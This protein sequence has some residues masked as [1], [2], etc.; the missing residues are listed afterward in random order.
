MGY[1]NFS[2]SFRKKGWKRSFPCLVY[3]RGLENVHRTIVV[4]LSLQPGR[5]KSLQQSRCERPPTS[6][7]ALFEA[8]KSRTL[9]PSRKQ[10]YNYHNTQLA[11]DLPFLRPALLPSL[12]PA[13]VLTDWALSQIAQP[14]EQPTPSPFESVLNLFLLRCSCWHKSASP[15]G[16]L[17]PPQREALQ[18]KWSLSSEGVEFM[19][20]L[21]CAVCLWPLLQAVFEGLTR[22]SQF[23]AKSAII[24]SVT[25][26]DFSRPLEATNRDS[27]LHYY[28]WNVESQ[29]LIK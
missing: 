8:G 27:Q 24:T 17:S 26:A 18:A 21:T 13:Q 9:V 29:S 15:G 25:E 14:K 11:R 20:P 5:Q 23:P 1:T 2:F 16:P 7:A 3:E 10:G 12:A 28:I 6:E 22:T 4:L 19:L